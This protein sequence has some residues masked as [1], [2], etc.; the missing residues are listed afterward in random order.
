MRCM[1]KCMY[2]VAFKYGCIYMIVNMSSY[3]YIYI[4]VRVYVYV[5]VYIY[6]NAY[7]TLMH[8]YKYIFVCITVNGEQ[9][10]EGQEH[11]QSFCINIGCCEWDSGQQQCLSAV[12]QTT[13]M[14]GSYTCIYFHTCVHAQICIYIHV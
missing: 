13:C 11:D 12:G 1:C 7:N 2:I 9:V 6:R 10:C 14:P 5:R 3:L 4:Y 8:A